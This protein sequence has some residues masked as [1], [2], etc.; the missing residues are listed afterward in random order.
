MRAPRSQPR[1]ALVAP[2]VVMFAIGAHAASVDGV[3]V[4]R[5][6]GSDQTALERVMA[7]E[8]IARRSDETTDKELALI[9]WGWTRQPVAALFDNLRAD[10][11]LRVDRSVVAY[12]EIDVD[13]LAASFSNLSLERTAI[14]ELRIAT[15]DGPLN[16]SQDELRAM[17]RARG[18]PG[19]PDALVHAYRRI[20][21]ERTAAYLAGG[22]DAVAPYARGRS[23]ASPGAELRSATEGYRVLKRYV[24][25]FYRA[26]ANFPHATTDW[27]LTHRFF[28]ILQTIEERPTVVL[29]HSMSGIRDGRAFATERQ[30]YVGRSYNASETVWGGLPAAVGSYVY[31]HNRT[32]TDRI[33]GIG[34]AF[35]K[36]IGRRMMQ[37][38][39]LRFLE[40]LRAAFE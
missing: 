8:L 6:L 4:A 17:S 31:Y 16:L 1:A 14:E 29:S 28:W 39:V 34:G 21:A 10:D 38:E 30:F 27:E 2:I 25:G 22:M 19:A 12:A 40:S 32:S 24:P 23:K 35:K 5:L 20:L 9:V 33:T 11:V 7:G 37:N 13:D 18:D 26:W 15:R 36:S 3:E